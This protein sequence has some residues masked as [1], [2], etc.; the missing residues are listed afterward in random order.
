MMKAEGSK[1][2]RFLYGIRYKKYKEIAQNDNVLIIIT[3]IYFSN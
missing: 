3:Y 1:T 2:F